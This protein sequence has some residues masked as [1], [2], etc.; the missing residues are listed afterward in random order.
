MNIN[1]TSHSHI[2]SHTITNCMHDHYS[3]QKGGMS[4]QAEMQQSVKVQPQTV[5]EVLQ[6][7]A[8]INREYDTKHAMFGTGNT[9]GDV[10]SDVNGQGKENIII[11][12]ADNVANA[13]S[14]DNTILQVTAD[15]LNEIVMPR[16]GSLQQSKILQNSNTIGIVSTSDT[17]TGSHLQEKK[18]GFL[19]FN[20]NG[21]KK[22]L[23]KWIQSF[24]EKFRQNKREHAN[25]N[26]EMKTISQEYI[27]DTYD[28]TG[29]YHQLEKR[30][31]INDTLNEK[32]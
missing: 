1:P 22:R 32:A 25:K 12:M 14:N 24:P 9:I 4:F 13:N 11:P 29:Q 6:E 17:T 20:T 26:K 27:L 28:K 19:P 23:R 5:E 3:V 18:K 31:I 2:E 30:S 7:L 16:K 15:M 21:I 8:T 10:I